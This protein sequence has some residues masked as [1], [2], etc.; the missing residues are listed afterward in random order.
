MQS[1]G[2]GDG[3]AVP[4]GN[5]RLAIGVGEEQMRDISFR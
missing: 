1:G 5:D 3:A 4:V 2:E